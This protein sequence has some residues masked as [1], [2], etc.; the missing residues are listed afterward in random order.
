MT[1]LGTEMCVQNPRYQGP[2]QVEPARP[3]KPDP[4]APR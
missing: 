2:A 4:R 3:R 1:R